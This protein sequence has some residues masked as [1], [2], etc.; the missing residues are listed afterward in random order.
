MSQPFILASASPRRRQLLQQA[1]C[2]F[3]VCPVDVDEAALPDES[4]LAYVHRVT[5]AKALALDSAG[6]QSCRQQ[7]RDDALSLA[8]QPL[9][10]AADT[11]V[12]L[13]AQLLGK[14]VDAAQARQTLQKL[15]G[16]THAVTTCFVLCRGD[17]ILQAEDVT[18]QVRFRKLSEAEIERYIDTGEPFD[19][20][21][22]YGIQGLGG[23][24]VEAVQG[25]YTNVVGLPLAE[26]LRGLHD[27]F[28]TTRGGA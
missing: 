28:V 4:A 25:S 26:V 14:P 1:G 13:D 17:E 20:A 8:E 19:K 27:S 9:I 2:R 11:I 24:L 15:S 12:H 22:A 16:R 5:R 6:I 3:V 18:T 21:G 23:F 7:A 10:L